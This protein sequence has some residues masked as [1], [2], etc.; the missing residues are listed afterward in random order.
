MHRLEDIV[1]QRFEPGFLDA[2]E[3]KIERNTS[4]ELV[5]NAGELYLSVGATKLDSVL[6]TASLA[7]GDTGVE[8]S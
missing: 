6:T 4:F 8:A 7:R 2:L 3:S 5:R 1:V